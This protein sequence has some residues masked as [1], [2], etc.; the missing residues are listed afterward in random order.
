MASS[1]RL[2]DNET[3][4]GAP[5]GGPAIGNKKADEKL[6]D[7]KKNMNP[8]QLVVDLVNAHASPIQAN[9]HRGLGKKGLTDYRTLYKNL[10]RMNLGR[11]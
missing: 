11:Y 3:V 1:G 4:P 10:Q 2:D 5:P 6:D 7:S 9:M 8:Y